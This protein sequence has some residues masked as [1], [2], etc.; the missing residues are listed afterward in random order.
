[1]DSFTLNPT[2]LICFHYFLYSIATA[3]GIEIKGNIWTNNRYALILP[4]HWFL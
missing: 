3:E 1:M 4:H 2:V